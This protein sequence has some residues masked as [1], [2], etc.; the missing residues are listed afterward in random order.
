MNAIIQG[1]AGVGRFGRGLGA[2]WCS[3]LLGVHKYSLLAWK[4]FTR[5]RYIV[6][7]PD[8][9]LSHMYTLGIETVPLVSIVAIFLGSET[10]V[11]SVYQMQ[12]FIPMRY[13]G[14]LVCKSVVTEL[15]PVVTS[16]IFAGR[17]ATGI[18]AEIGSMKTSEQLDAMKVLSLD[19]IRYLIVPK[20]VACIVM[21]PVLVIW[22]DFLAIAGATVMAFFSIDI[23]MFHFAD[24]LKLFFNPMDV[25][26]GVFKTAV[27]GAIIAITG[28]YFG[29]ETK[30][31]AE[32]V[33]N[34][35][36]KAVVTSAVLV[37]VFDFFIALL[38]L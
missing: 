30:G 25:F 1:V 29:F 34:A 19:S 35:T 20:T 8:L 14:V 21:L 36:T 3:F 33:G 6:Y 23:T 16:I 5:L 17:V 28:A 32:G 15:G 18:A 9:T 7:N 2:L 31:G 22:A 37:L 12:G 10:V 26:F 13:L 4:T 27:F 38:V 11:Q 24:S